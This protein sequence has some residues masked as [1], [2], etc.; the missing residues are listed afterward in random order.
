MTSLSDRERRFLR[1]QQR[2]ESNQSDGGMEVDQQDSQPGQQELEPLQEEDV[3]EQLQT[4]H[5]DD[6]QEEL[7]PQETKEESEKSE[8]ARK[9]SSLHILIVSFYSC[10]FLPKGRT[11]SFK[12]DKT[13]FVE[14]D[15]ARRAKMS[16]L[17]FT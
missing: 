9:V 6:S 12:I 2:L 10:L 13:K 4:D 1:R 15:K 8:Q 16:K 5:V 3:P 14:N 7:P 11:Q 17:F